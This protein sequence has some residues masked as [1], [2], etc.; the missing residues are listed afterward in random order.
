MKPILCYYIVVPDWEDPK[1]HEQKQP[2]IMS[3]SNYANYNY[4]IIIICFHSILINRLHSIFHFISAFAYFMYKM[5]SAII[6][7]YINDLFNA[8]GMDFLK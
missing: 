8:F 3:F 1:Y 6:T 2:F 5:L 4:N 7:S